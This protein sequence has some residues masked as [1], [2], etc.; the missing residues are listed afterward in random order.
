MPKKVHRRSLATKPQ[1]R[2]MREKAIQILSTLTPTDDDELYC[3]LCVLERKPYKVYSSLTELSQH[4]LSHRRQR[5]LFDS[6]DQKMLEQAALQLQ[7]IPNNQLNIFK[8]LTCPLCLL[9][10]KY[11]LYSHNPTS[12]KYHIKHNH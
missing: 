9:D 5:P 6:A 10:Y 2:K 4:I 1:Y 12:L 7:T 3:P 8:N 11:N